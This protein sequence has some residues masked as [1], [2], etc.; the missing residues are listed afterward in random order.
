MLKFAQGAITTVEMLQQQDRYL[1]ALNDYLQSKY[2]Y[3]LIE[4][5][6]DIYTGKEIKL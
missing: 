6:L 1:S 3:I 4:K 5:Q 2:N